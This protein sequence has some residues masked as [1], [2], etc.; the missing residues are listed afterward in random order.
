M[1]TREALQPMFPVESLVNEIELGRSIFKLVFPQHFTDGKG[2]LDQAPD[3]LTESEFIECC[4]YYH[5]RQFACDYEFIAFS[6][7]K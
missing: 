5:T 3:E 4:L 6:C 2:G 7:K 1:L